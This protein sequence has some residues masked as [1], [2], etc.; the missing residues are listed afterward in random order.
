MLSFESAALLL[1]LSALFGWLN[2]RFLHWPQATGLL[3][4]GLLTSFVLVG[5]AAAFPNRHVHDALVHA[6]L[7]VDFSNL[8]MNGMLAFL[9]FAGALNIDFQ[10][11]RARAVPVAVLALLGT[12]LSTL[13]V[14]LAFW[15]V[16]T[17]L[18]L[19]LPFVWALLFGALISPTDPVAVLAILKRIELPAALKVEL[20]GE[21]LFNDGV[22]V[23]LYTLLL[24]LAVGSSEHGDPSTRIPCFSCGRW[25]AASFSAWRPATSPTA[26]C[27]R[28][29]S[30]ESRS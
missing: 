6:L 30:S 28:L 7:D 23:V 1:C 24:G 26:R 25:S 3:L 17:W 21:A 27:R 16:A 9:L 11:L 4:A 13:L 22:G 5:V 14:G 18:G 20:E 10:V 12:I 19:G 29:T 15:T 8:V 2:Q